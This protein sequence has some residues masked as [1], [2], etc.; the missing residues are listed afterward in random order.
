MMTEAWYDNFIDA[1]LAKYPKK[2]QLTQAL[3]EL[4]NIEREAVYRRL[5]KD[6]AFPA[7][8]IVTIAST[9]NISL[10]AVVGIDAGQVSFQMRQVN[11]LDPSEE[12]ANFLRY[13]IQSINF[14]KQF[15]NTEFMDVCNKLPRQLLAGFEHLNQFYLFKWRYEYGVDEVLPYS[16]LVI[17]EEKAQLTA[18]YYRTIKD[19]PTSSFIWDQ[20][21][22]EH[23]VRDIQYFHSIY[24]IT[25]E[26]KELIRKDLYRLLSYMQEVAN[27]GYYPETQNRV[28]LYVS[29]LNIDTNYSYSFT[30]DVNVCFIHAFEKHEI[31]TFNSEMVTNFR[32]WMQLKKRTAI[33][34]SEVDEKSR[35][36]FF[37]RQNQLVDSL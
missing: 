23:L 14:V 37:M 33:Q 30:P 25:D 15:P 11:Y 22:F 17:S 20:R 24:L 7:D 35:V 31:Y 36:E 26:E 28:N 1:L 29:Q 19:V 6:V 13:I 8:E 34:I 12:E 3:T 10:D 4:L 5:R 18:T 27:K 32:A 16:Q 21:I 9:W 2:N